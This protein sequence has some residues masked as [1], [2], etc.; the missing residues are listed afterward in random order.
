[1]K[2][3]DIV[4]TE[5]AFASGDLS[6]PALITNVNG[7]DADLEY[8]SLPEKQIRIGGYETTGLVVLEEKT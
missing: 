8:V 5:R 1:M 6:Y 2:P 7:I 4:V 3:G